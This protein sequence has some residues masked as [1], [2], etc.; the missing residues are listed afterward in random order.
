MNVILIIVKKGYF[1]LI[2]CIFLIDYNIFVYF[3]FNKFQIYKHFW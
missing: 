3:K 2:N 1:D